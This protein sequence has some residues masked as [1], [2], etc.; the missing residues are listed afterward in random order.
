MS[1][2]RRAAKAAKRQ[3]HGADHGLLRE[4]TERALTQLFNSTQEQLQLARRLL[5]TVLALGNEEPLGEPPACLGARGLGRQSKRHPAGGDDEDGH[6]HRDDVW[7]AAPIVGQHRTAG[8]DDQGDDQERPI[9]QRGDALAALGDE[10]EIDTVAEDLRRQ[11]VSPAEF[12][13]R[14]RRP[15][16]GRGADITGQPPTQPSRIRDEKDQDEGGP[17]QQEGDSMVKSALISPLVG[18]CGLPKIRTRMH[19]STLMAAK[20]ARTRTMRAPG[21]PR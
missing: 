15:D 6:C 11:T 10:D 1:Q 19:Q 9:Q 18:A 20:P 16:Y 7:N 5:A 8:D 2:Q 17:E 3:Q 14:P 21:R 13:Q 12:L 4:W